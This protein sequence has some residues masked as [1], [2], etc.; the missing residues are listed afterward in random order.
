MYEQFLSAR[1][2]DLRAGGQYHPSLE[3]ALGEKPLT[4]PHAPTS[5]STDSG[6]Y[7]PT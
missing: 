1:L 2:R 5:V 6:S 4:S 3:G 7:A